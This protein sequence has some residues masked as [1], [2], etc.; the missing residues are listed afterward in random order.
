MSDTVSSPSS[1]GKYLGDIGRTPLLTA[2]EERELGR[3]LREGAG[4][5]RKQARDKLILSNLRLVVSLAKKYRGQG[6][7][8]DDLIQ[9]GNI[10]LMTAVE[11]FDYQRGKRFSTMA[12]WW[13]RHA[14]TRAIENQ[15]G[16]V[17]VPV[18]LAEALSKIKKATKRHREETGHS[19]TPAELA[20]C[21]RIPE[22]W[23]RA[24]TDNVL[25]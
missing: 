16:G 13:I 11:K 12:T 10:G 24:V 19:P 17:R 1:L 6:V 8:F 9:E 23:V 7:A 4:G 25:A 15:G 20:K 18:Y 14:L 21:L 2:D 22:R 3:A 5:V